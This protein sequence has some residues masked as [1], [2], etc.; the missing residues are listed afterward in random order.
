MKIVVLDG[1]TLNP[2]DLSWTALEKLGEVT[3][4][5]RT[6][7]DEVV[8]R[9]EDAQIV[10]VNKTRLYAD[11]IALLP[12]LKYI[13]IVATG[14]NVVDV[15]AALRRG[16]V[17][18]NVPTY[19]SESVAQHIFSLILTICNHSERLAAE[20]RRG[21]WGSDPEFAYSMFPYMEIAGKSIGIVGYGNIGRVVADIAFGF[22]M[23]VLAYSSKSQSQLRRVEKC[24]LDDLFRRSDVVCM[25]CPL[26]D[27]NRGMVSK[28][29][30]DKMKPTA[31]FINTARGGLVDE[32]ALADALNAGKIYAA[33]LDVLS[34][35]PP[36]H[37]NILLSARNCYVTPHIAWATK[38]ARGRCLDIAV[39]NVRAYLDGK[40]QNVI[41]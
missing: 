1:Y 6:S 31:I 38:E 14:L 27:Q 41:G 15:D 37:G 32:V 39:A 11:Q 23:R 21:R 35:E 28:A 13:G 4:Y 12:H 29:L 18:T 20:D 22:G 3:V 7:R 34:A 17:V 25:C 9:S 36:K 10:L 33:G 16:I 8:P 24:A 40:P 5:D 2:G 26:T 19:G 30:L